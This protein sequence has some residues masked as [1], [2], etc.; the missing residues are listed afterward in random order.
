[1]HSLDG[2]LAAR[3]RDNR[4]RGQRATLLLG[5]SIICA[6]KIIDKT[7]Q[8]GPA[9]RCRYTVETI[10]Q[11][12]TFTSHSWV[13]GAGLSRTTFCSGLRCPRNSIGSTSGAEPAH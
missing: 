5:L 13:V 10:G 7:I 12:A 9:S 6:R 2:W 8:R 1:M 11:P 3:G 4:D